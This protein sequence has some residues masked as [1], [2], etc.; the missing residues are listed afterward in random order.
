MAQQAL[1]GQA[2]ELTKQVDRLSESI[3]FLSDAYKDDYPGPQLQDE[4]VAVR[5]AI[6]TAVNG[7]WCD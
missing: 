3:A 7:S 5:K 4:V 6:D 1:P 2:S